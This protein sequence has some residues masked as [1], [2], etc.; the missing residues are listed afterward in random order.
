MMGAFEL[1][2]VMNATL[3]R[4]TSS[5]PVAMAMGHSIPDGLLSLN[6]HLRVAAP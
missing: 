3:T 6:S 2:I 5:K 4:I 1:A